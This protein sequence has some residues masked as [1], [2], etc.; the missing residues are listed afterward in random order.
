[1]ISDG[2]A[3]RGFQNRT[4]FFLEDCCGENLHFCP[5]RT[6]CRYL[7]AGTELALVT[8]PDDE[9]VYVKRER[10]RT[11]RLVIEKV[12]QLKEVLARPEEWECLILNG[13][14]ITMDNNRAVRWAAKNGLLEAVKFLHGCGA[15]ITANNND[16][17]KHAAGNGHLEV[18]KYL[19]E[20]GADITADDNYAVRTAAVRGHLETA[21]YLNE[22]GADITA[23]DNYAL[24]LAAIKGR[25]E[26]VKYLHE[27]GADM[28]S[29][30]GYAIKMAE[31][32]G[33]LDVVVY[34][35]ENM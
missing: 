35:R 8:V 14:D 25:L 17:V 26:I 3:M 1:M 22:N 23:A 29:C 31:Y 4:G 27:N 20:N 24:K 19:H 16:A 33:Y 2:M 10:F 11:H 9:K 28:T 6:V 7:D 34:L 5:V 13:A 32:K 18:V 30:K 21:K 12:F 15:D